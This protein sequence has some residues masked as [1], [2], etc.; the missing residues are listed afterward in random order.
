MR[1]LGQLN[2]ERLLARTR[3]SCSTKPL[4]PFR[5]YRLS[6]KAP[7]QF[8]MKN[9]HWKQF[10]LQH[11]WLR[12]RDG[13]NL[14]QF[15]RRLFLPCRL[16]NWARHKH[17]TWPYQPLHWNTSWTRRHHGLFYTDASGNYTGDNCTTVVYLCQYIASSSPTQMIQRSSSQ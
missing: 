7:L 6:N 17:S 15:R 10:Y 3:C 16:P 8:S 11:S 1:H 9:H 2:R 12:D 14:Q 5:T 13:K 4:F